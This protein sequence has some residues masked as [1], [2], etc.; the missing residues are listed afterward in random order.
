MRILIR[1]L[2]C[3]NKMIVILLYLFYFKVMSLKYYF[4]FLFFI[5][6]YLNLLYFILFLK[7][8]GKKYIKTTTPNQIIQI[9]EI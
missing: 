7:H 1:Y 5:L 3:A 6:F 9:F 8:V 4:T 2:L